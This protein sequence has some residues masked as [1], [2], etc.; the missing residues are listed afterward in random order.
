MALERK[1]QRPGR[2][3][4]LLLVD[5][6]HGFTDPNS[7]LGTEC[8]SVI[9][10]NQTLL[11]YFAAAGWPVFFS[12]VVYDTESQARVFRA[13][14]PALNILQRGS[15]W[16]EVDSRLGQPEPWQLI[17]K[18]WASAFFGTDL[19]DRLRAQ[20]A[21]S[22]V[23]TGLTTSGC[24]RAT[25]VDGLQHDY[26]VFIPREAVGDRTEAVHRANLYDLNAKYVDVVDLTELLGALEGKHGLG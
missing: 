3:P 1:S 25:A 17:E 21:D 24:V 4:A 13:R 22:L 14:L 26:P 20:T 6:S 7:P 19:I 23:V 16:V 2:R 11:R 10:A 9:E 18:H 12:T 5:L 15:H 8:G